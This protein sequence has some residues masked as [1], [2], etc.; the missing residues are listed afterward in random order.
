MLRQFGLQARNLLLSQV[1]LNLTLVH[2]LET[3]RL[4]R[5]GIGRVCDG[6]GDNL[7]QD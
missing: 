1:P 4:S 7:F 3:D 2:D 5:F 6:A